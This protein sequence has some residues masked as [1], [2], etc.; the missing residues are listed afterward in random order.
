MKWDLSFSCSGVKYRIF[1]SEKE[2][3]K[4]I[5]LDEKQVKISRRLEEPSQHQ[6]LT[7]PSFLADALWEA[8]WGTPVCSV[9]K[10]Y[11]KEKNQPNDHKKAAHH[12]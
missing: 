8:E 12:K 6:G 5:R 7:L 3:K 4:R 2:E 11:Y 1:S 10:L 9:K